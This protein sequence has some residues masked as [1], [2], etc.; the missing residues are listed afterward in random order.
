MSIAEP[1]PTIIPGPKHGLGKRLAIRVEWPT[2]LVLTFCYGGMAGLIAAWDMIPLWLA[3]PAAGYLTAL[4]GSLT[5]EAVHGHPTGKGWLNEALVTVPLTLW[6]PFRRYRDW[7][8]AHHATHELSSPIDDSESHFVSKHAW[9]RM[10][11]LRRA[12]LW[13]DQTILGRLT[14]GA[15]STVLLYWA[16]EIAAL[17]R[18]DTHI[19]RSWCLHGLGLALLILFIEAF[20]GLSLWE[21]ALYCALPGISLTAL[22]T[23]LE[24]QPGPDQAKRC[25]IVESC[26]PIGFLFLF[27]NLHLVHHDRPG[28]PWYRIPS[29]YRR[30]KARYLSRNGGYFYQGYG[31]ILIRHLV[32]PKEHPAHP[33][34]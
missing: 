11:P 18:G 26:L 10:G 28:M 6:I 3:I 31:E 9:A 17:A 13:A 23:Y 22:R 25:A 32:R 1:Q 5:H 20:G 7:H 29:E 30:N 19:W 15:L 2:V 27:N 14:F 12:V 16:R 21:Y 8:I 24:H 34:F 4:H 33:T